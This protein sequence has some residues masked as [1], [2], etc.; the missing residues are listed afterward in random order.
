M[1]V[2]CMMSGLK[3]TNLQSSD[4]SDAHEYR[5][6]HRPNLEPSTAPL[7]VK[8]RGLTHDPV[9]REVQHQHHHKTSAFNPAWNGKKILMR[10]GLEPTQLS[11]LAP[12]ASALTAR[13]SHQIEYERIKFKCNI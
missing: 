10:V 3:R 11:L 7:R 13:P 12:E 8:A 5:P 4:S 1:S 9:N 6:Q 2:V